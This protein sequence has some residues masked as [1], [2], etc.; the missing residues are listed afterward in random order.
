MTMM[1]IMMILMLMITPG[2]QTDIGRLKSA[3]QP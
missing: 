2:S 1:M 3:V